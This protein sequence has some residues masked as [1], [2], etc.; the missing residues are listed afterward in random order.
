M[1]KSAYTKTNISKLVKT[2]LP[3]IHIKLLRKYKGKHNLVNKFIYIPDVVNGGDVDA[4]KALNKA[5]HDVNKFM[6]T[7]NIKYDLVAFS[8]DKLMKLKFEYLIENE[9]TGLCSTVWLLEDEEGWKV[10]KIAPFWNLYQ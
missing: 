9:E 10:T 1:E 8:F 2:E 4:V 6:K 5:T 7:E 3:E